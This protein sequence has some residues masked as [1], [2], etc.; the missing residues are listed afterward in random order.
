M[1]KLLTLLLALV[2]SVGTIF[3]EIIE[4]VKIDDLYYTLDTENQ[5]AEVASDGYASGSIEIPSSV[6]YNDIDYEVT[7]ISSLAFVQ[8]SD[9]T[10]IEIPNSVT[11]IG[12][13]A[14]DRCS[15]LI[16][17]SIGKGVKSIGEGAFYGCSS[18]TS[19]Y[20]SDL[21]DWC[22]IDF[23]DADYP[24]GCYANPLLLQ[25]SNYKDLYLNDEL[26]TNLV[27]PN[28]VT[29]ISNYLF[30]GCKS[31]TSVTIPNGV[32]SI[33]FA[34]FDYCPN[35]NKI[36]ISESVTTIGSGAFWYCGALTSITC[37][38]T[39]PPVCD[40]SAFYLDVIR[41][42]CT[43]YVPEQ[44]LD[45]YNDADVWKEFDNIQ[46]ITDEETAIENPSAKFGGSRKL[47]RQGNIYILTDDSHTYTLTG[48]QI[49]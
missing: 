41:H 22:A 49:K 37:R 45:L 14:F 33:G 1:K 12:R 20:I 31:I 46:A 19:V 44:S 29:S 38:A 21:A 39:T 16:S 3:A 25:A 10:N 7:R 11:S 48:Q 23:E 4:R 35:L 8:C 42:D 26:V 2:T 34:A 43:L 47:L 28:N 18:L 32:T 5:T 13:S 15:D 17:V 36:D 30:C 6:I 9:L 27:I 24:S 40:N